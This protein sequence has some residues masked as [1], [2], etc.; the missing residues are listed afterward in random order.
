MLEPRK[1]RPTGLIK[2]FLCLFHLVVCNNLYAIDLLGVYS[3]ALANDPEYK[4]QVLLQQAE[5]QK[6]PQ[7]KSSLMPSLNANAL[8]T[9]TNQKLVTDIPFI[10]QGSANFGSNSFG[11]QL[12]QK[13]YDAGAFSEY[14][15]A[16]IEENLSHLELQ[17]AEQDLMLRVSRAYF[18]VLQAIERALLAQ[19]NSRALE[20]QFE[21]VK[22]RSDVGL[23]TVGEYQQSLARWQLAIPDEI[24][25]QIELDNAVRELELISGG[26]YL[27]L[28]NLCDDAEIDTAY[29]LDKDNWLQ[30]VMQGNLD[31]IKEDNNLE[32]S[33]KQLSIERARRLP[34]VELVGNYGVEN[35]DGSLAGPSS[36][37]KLADVSLQFSLPLFDGKFARSRILEAKYRL[38]AQ[39]HNRVKTQ[40]EIIN[41]AKELYDR[42]QTQKQ[43]LDAL[44]SAVVAG[45]L[46][47]NAKEESFKV[48][49]ETNLGV[50]DAQRDLFEASLSANQ[51]RYDTLILNLELEQIVGNL[52]I[53]DLQKVNAALGCSFSF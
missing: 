13:V 45:E 22:S 18:N 12:R 3:N 11:L 19:S 17:K 35:S 26:R 53:N 4:S 36:R 41:S 23:G 40:T 25:A 15:K 2:G 33:E 44:K 16:K 5:L 39:R 32:I 47:L 8:T 7:A 49:L 10:T 50:L 21:Q 28:N 34:K 42:V 20:E 9:L 51:A 38:Q 43:V 1:A 52:D 29:Q 14:K 24:Q 27:T 46:V 31:Y 30:S 48:G 37:N 6:L